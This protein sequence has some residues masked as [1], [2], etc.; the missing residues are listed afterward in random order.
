[1]TGSVA[2]ATNLAARFALEL[3]ML[4]ALGYVG[5][6]L[7]DGLAAEIGLAVALPLAAAVVWG[8]AIAPKARRRAPDPGRAALELVVFAAA[9]A[10][11]VA[12][13]HAVLGLLLA[14]AVVVNVGLMF[15]WGQRQTA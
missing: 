4:A 13:G 1:M 5:F 6:Q 11:L 10:G 3:C 7:G 12:T 9:S 15:V 2:R 8:A 14:V